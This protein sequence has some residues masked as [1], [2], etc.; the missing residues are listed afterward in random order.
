MKKNFW[1]ADIGGSPRVSTET[2]QEKEDGEYSSSECLNDARSPRILPPSP[3]FPTTSNLILSQGAL[4]G[5]K[6]VHL[7]YSTPGVR[8]R[9]GLASC[10][11]STAGA[12]AG[13]EVAEEGGWEGQRGPRAPPLLYNMFITKEVP[14]WNTMRRRSRRRERRRREA[15][16]GSG[17][18][19][20]LREIS[21]S[22]ANIA[23]LLQI[24]YPLLSSSQQA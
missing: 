1:Q 21:S 11:V 10:A 4:R 23:S 13:L 3:L 19:M 18:C 6:S 14:V 2:W 16:S 8:G 20:P 15:T 17:L 12:A 22:T 9:R 5:P 7:P 24:L